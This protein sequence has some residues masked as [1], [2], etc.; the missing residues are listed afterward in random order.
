[1]YDTINRIF[2]TGLNFAGALPR[3]TDALAAQRV[4]AGIEEL[5]EVIRSIQRAVFRVDGEAR[6]SDTP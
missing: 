3:I 1:M 2:S 6:P 4:Q 5:D